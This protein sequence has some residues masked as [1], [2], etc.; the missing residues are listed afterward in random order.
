LNGVAVA[1]NLEA[2]K[3]GREAA[4][5]DDTTLTVKAAHKAEIEDLDT[6]IERLKTRLRAYQGPL[7]ARRFAKFV[8]AVRAV[9]TKFGAELALTRAVADGYHKLLAYKDEYEVARLYASKAFTDGLAETFRAPVKIYF[10]MAPPALSKGVGRVKK[11]EFGAWLLPLLR[12]LQ[13]FKFLR[14]TPLDPFGYSAE[15]KL[16]RALGE[17]YRRSLDAALARLTAD[18]HGEVLALARLAMEIRGYGEVKLD[19]LREVLPRWQALEQRLGINTLTL[20]LP[21]AAQPAAALPAS[22]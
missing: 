9:D 7:Y 13:H 16:E 20:Q 8:E 19:A 17:A 22:S 12:G 10:H 2:F 11:R 5:V 18:N 4:M 3:L 1:A 21:A 14:G 15:R 6:H